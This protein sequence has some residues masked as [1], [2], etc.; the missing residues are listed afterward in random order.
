[1]DQKAKVHRILFKLKSYGP[2]EG[3]GW[4]ENWRFQG[5]L[6]MPLRFDTTETPPHQ[7]VHAGSVE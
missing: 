2:R 5:H 6:F 7:Y 3:L 4:L 1:M